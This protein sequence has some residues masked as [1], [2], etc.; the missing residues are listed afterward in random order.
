MKKKIFIASGIALAVMIILLILALNNEEA[1]PSP[2]VE[3]SETDPHSEKSEEVIRDQ[4]EVEAGIR[5]RYEQDTYTLES[6]YVVQNPYGTMPLTGLVLFETDEPMEITVTVEGKREEG[7]IVHR[8]SGYETEHRIPV[9]GLYA[10]HDNTVQI[11]GETEAG[12]LEETE[13][14]F[15]TEPIPEDFLSLELVESQPDQ[16]EEGLT[17]MIP[18]R[19]YPYAVDANGEIRWYSS[20]DTQHIFERLEN[21]NILI[22]VRENTEEQFD[23]LLEI[24]LL[25]Q[26]K[27]HYVVTVDGYEG[28]AV[29]HHDAIELPDGNLLA[30]V[31]DG[32]G[33]VED[34]M[35]EI[36]RETG[37]TVEVIDFK[38]FFPVESY[39]EYNGT[40]ASEDEVDWFHQ[41]AVFYDENDDS[42]VVSGRHQDT[43]FK[44]AY[45]S[46][47]IEW[48]LAAHEAWPEEG[49]P[50][51]F[52]D[53]LVTA[54][55]EEFKFPG[56]QHAPIILPDQDNKE[57]TEDVLLFDNNI[58]V[59]RGD[60][61]LSETF[62]RAVQY[63][64]DTEEL[65]VEEV[66]S[67]GEERGEDFYSRIVGDANF[68]PTTGN[69]LLTSGYIHINEEDME[70]RIVEVTGTDPAEV[71][72]ELRVYGFEEGS[73]VQMYR[74]KRMELYPEEWDFSW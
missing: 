33:Y 48:V 58:A 44:M 50:S 15:V 67:Y 7:T 68:L 28:P 54:A 8:F 4:R 12:E 62:S 41:N 32:P 71:V 20:F 56:G 37:E 13:L 31:H 45:P 19:N 57:E 60:E 69:R 73:R 24:D 64:I 9:I 10:D 51:D 61:E 26:V 3:E 65:T 14:S 16:M 43:V 23:Q 59:T 34:E 74:A 27:N 18:S 70:S 49:W 1:A 42:I 39:Q 36:D 72:F 40:G 6:P 66:W 53:K 52:Q 22:A 2:N 55:E 47:E 17:W 30:T 11:R 25:G 5:E 21:G 63:R 35:I 46:G 38:E 29:I